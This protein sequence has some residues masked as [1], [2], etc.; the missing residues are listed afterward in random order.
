MFNLGKV[1]ISIYKKDTNIYMSILHPTNFKVFIISS[2]TSGQVYG[3][4]HIES[5]SANK[6][7]LTFSFP[8]YICYCSS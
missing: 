1:I 2:K 5:Y 4:W 8:I 7:N 6:G 3:L